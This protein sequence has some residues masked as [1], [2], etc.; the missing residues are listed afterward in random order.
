MSSGSK[1][2]NG[3]GFHKKMKDKVV[4]MNTKSR[5]AFLGAFLIT[6]FVSAGPVFAKP[7]VICDDVQQPPSLNPYQVFS[8]KVHTLVQQIMEGLVRFDTEGQI[9]PALAERWERINDTTMRFY[10]R[11]GVSFHNGEPFNA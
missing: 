8:E 6:I 7:I 10:L 3:F 1:C 9:E 2:N 11:K 4:L 5:K